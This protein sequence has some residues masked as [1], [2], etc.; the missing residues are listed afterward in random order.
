LPNGG[1]GYLPTDILNLYN[2]LVGLTGQGQTIGILKFSDG[3]SLSD[4]RAFW[5]AA[6]MEQPQLTFVSVDCTRNDGV[7][8]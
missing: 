7:T 5:Q 3:Y 1:Q 4:A 6:G 8:A 2:F